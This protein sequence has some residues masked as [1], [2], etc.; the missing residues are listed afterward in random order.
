MRP[1]VGRRWWTLARP[2]IKRATKSTNCIGRRAGR[3]GKRRGTAFEEPGGRGE[4]AMT[5]MGK[6]MFVILGLAALFAGTLALRSERPQPTPVAK[7]SA[8]QAA[9]MQPPP[10]PAAPPKSQPVAAQEPGEPDLDLE[11]GNGS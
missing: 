6:T 7:L 5:T 1:P 8:A 3:R 9:E 10:A 2:E 4:T 11:D